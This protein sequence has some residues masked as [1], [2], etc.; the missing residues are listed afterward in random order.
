[1]ARTNLARARER[2]AEFDA[3][4]PVLPDDTPV[5]LLPVRLETRFVTDADGRA[6]L[7]RVYPDEIHVDS[8]QPGLTSGEVAAGEAYAALLAAAGSDPEARRRAFEQLAG[9]VGTTRALYVAQLSETG[10]PAPSDVVR[11]AHSS[12]LPDR[13]TVHGYRGTTR[14]VTAAGLP[15]PDGLPLG[16]APNSAPPAE[17]PPLDEASRWLVDFPAAVKVGMALRV[18]M[19]DDGGLDRLIVLGVRADDDAAGSGKR[20]R[21]MLEGHRF[22]A[23]L[24]VLPPGT[25]TNNT[26][27]ERSGWTRRPDARELF[28]AAH[29]SAGLGEEDTGAAAFALGLAPETLAGLVHAGSSSALHARAMHR[30]LWP[31]TLGYV[32]ETLGGTAVDDT[33]IEAARKL[34]I[35]S[36]RGLGPLPLLRIG[37]QPYGMLPVT[38]ARAWLPA[39]D[40][41]AAD[42]VVRLLRRLT[43]EWLAA[44]GRVPH[45]GRP[46]ADPDQELLDILGREAVSGGYRLRPVRGGLLSA[47]IAPLVADLDPTGRPLAE[48]AFQLAGGQASPPLSRMAFDPRTVRIRR[49]PVLAGPLS[50][51]EPLPGPEGGGPN[52][53]RYLASRSERDGPYSGPGASTLLRALAERSAKLADLDAAVRFSRP[54]SVAAAKSALEAEVIDAVP[55]RPTATPARLLARPVRET[56]PA[57]P[58]GV[59]VEDFIA[60]ATPQQVAALGLPHV[61]AAFGRTTDVRR[62]LAE[63]SS[64]PS[65]E[66]DRL[67]RTALDACSHRLDAWLTAV[68]TQRLAE[69]RNAHPTGAYVGGYGWVD[70]LVPKPAAQ[71]AP[72]LPR[73]EDGPLVVDPTN[74]GYVL[75]PSLTQ[76]STAAL[77][78]SGHLSHR[79]SG[80]AAAEAFAVDLS[81]DRA[82]VAT[83][84]LDGV[85]QGQPLGALLGYRFERGLH[86]RSRPGLEL[87]RFIRPIRSLAPIVADAADTHE[88]VEAMAASGVVD[89]LELLRRWR[90]EPAFVT[91]RLGSA[92]PPATASERAAVQAELE[93]MAADADAVADLVLAETVHQMA[94]GN[95]ARAAAMS[96]AVSSGQGPPPEPDVLRTPRPAHDYQHRLVTLVPMSTTAAPGWAAARHRRRAEPRLERWVAGL[97]G[98]ASSIRAAARVVDQAGATTVQELTL[99]DA[100]VCA[101]DVVHG[102]DLELLLAEALAVATDAGRAEIIQS[103]DADWPGETWPAD[104]VPLEDA[105]VQGRW[106]AE[107]LGTARPLSTADLDP[108]GRPADPDLA[109]LAGRADAAEAAFRAAAEELTSAA[110]P[111]AGNADRLRTALF[112]MAGFGVRGVAA[113]LKDARAPGADTAAVLAGAAVAT[114]AEAARAIAAIDAAPGPRAALRAVFGDDFAVLPVCAPP[115][116][117]SEAVI[118]CDTVDF[119]GNEPAAPLAWLQRTALVRAP[120]DRYL[121]ATAGGGGRYAPVQVPPASRWIGLRLTGDATLPDH[122]LSVLVHATGDQAAAPALAGIVLDEWTDRLPESSGT[123]GVA[124]HFDEP[125]ARAPQAVLVAVPPV[126]GQAWTADGLLDVVRETADL[127]RI[128]MVGPE[129]VPWLGRFLP[130]LLVADNTAG[131]TVGMDLVPLVAREGGVG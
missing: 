43:P 74:S 41:D 38:S 96:D 24:D 19:P 21:A 97:L 76:A 100:G 55:Q 101:L 54:A 110:A 102:D 14:V 32:L 88:A 108:Q 81:S 5:V 30:A 15:I 123:A 69:V 114:L 46:G 107:S 39:Q 68:A 42:D 25:A 35:E 4:V 121:L 129:E 87:D 104:V 82:R 118:A 85:R 36:V 94:S 122:A 79:G 47:A 57:A 95:L 33:T 112:A 45:V 56:I 90:D 67:T 106:I 73:G 64:V 2:L 26:G 103:G 109:E 16:P 6:L 27:E 7:V 3:A 72:Q 9:R 89:G 115:A 93:S 120:V 86:D 91:S 18:P 111:D 78:L 119:V 84:L 31:A 116:G 63:L 51:T 11:P 49:A 61:R 1:M 75:A 13:W 99:A 52:Y 60:T 50:E 37:A 65:A 92:T 59:S 28:D 127:A 131:D 40:G 128:R 62:A 17:G 77:L 8:H 10:L 126:L 80:G 83:W 124:L 71:P 117:W 98:P 22:G 34:F 23:G 58:V 44:A 105:L 48:A 20:L 53:L 130:A 125:G 113:A 66:L 70:G 29:P 12:V